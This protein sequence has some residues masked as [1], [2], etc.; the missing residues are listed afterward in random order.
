MPTDSGTGPLLVNQV[1]ARTITVTLPGWKPQISAYRLA[2]HR[3]L[4]RDGVEQTMG[5]PD[6]HTFGDPGRVT[7][8][9]GAG[10]LAFDTQTQIG[11]TVVTY[12]PNG[13]SDPDIS[14]EV[15]N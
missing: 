6:T 15:E 2:Q 10:Q 5:D 12:W 13:F 7:V 3:N 1:P 14:F 8:A 4:N 11:D 9:D